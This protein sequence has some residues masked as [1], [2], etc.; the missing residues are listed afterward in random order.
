MEEDEEHPD[1]MWKKNII[2]SEKKKHSRSFCFFQFEGEEYV[3]SI[4][5]QS[6]FPKTKNWC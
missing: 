1:G 5:K 6:L 4:Q 3:S 2:W